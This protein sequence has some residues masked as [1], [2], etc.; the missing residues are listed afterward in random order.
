MLQFHLLSRTYS[1][2]IPDTTLTKAAD[3]VTENSAAYLYTHSLDLNSILS[4]I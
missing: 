1:N 4:S 3:R 2:V